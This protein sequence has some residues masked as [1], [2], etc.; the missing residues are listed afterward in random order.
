MEFDL[1]AIEICTMKKLEVTTITSVKEIH[2]Q[3]TFELN[4][5]ARNPLLVKDNNKEKTY[6]LTRVG[7]I[8]HGLLRKM[9]VLEGIQM[10]ELLD[11]LLLEYKAKKHPGL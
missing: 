8:P 7:L 2:E 1:Q 4:T 3:K 5:I 10:Q 9:A 6:T 11:R